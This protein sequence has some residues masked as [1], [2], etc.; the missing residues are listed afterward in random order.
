M[1]DKRA[2]WSLFVLPGIDQ[3]LGQADAGVGAGDGD[4]P[5]GGALHRVGDL[6]LSAR[7]LTDLVDLGA[8]AADDAADELRERKTAMAQT[9]GCQ[10]PG[11]S[12]GG[13]VCAGLRRL[14][15]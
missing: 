1:C 15:W 3:V 13:G 14:E 4:L 11:K 2:G 10:R 7:H 12:R 8:L 6:D 9:G 5:V